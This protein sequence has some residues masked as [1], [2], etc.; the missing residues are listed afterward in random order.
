MRINSSL[1]LNEKLSEYNKLAEITMVQVLGSIEDERTFNN[2]S[3][4]KNEFQNR[5]TTHLDLWVRRFSQKKI[6]IV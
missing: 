6:H 5:L 1:I 2:L 3:F 4:M